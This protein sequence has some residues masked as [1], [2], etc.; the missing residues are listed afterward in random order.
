MS[1]TPD[2]EFVFTFGKGCYLKIVGWR[3]LIALAFL[4]IAVAVWGYN[5]KD[6]V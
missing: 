5:L 4:I 2:L 6:W 3:G 1:D